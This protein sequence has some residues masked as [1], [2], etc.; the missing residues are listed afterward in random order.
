MKKI[1]LIIFLLILYKYSNGQDAVYISSYPE[2]QYKTKEDFINKRIWDTQAVYMMSFPPFSS[3]KLDSPED[4]LFFHY[5]SSGDKV[6]NMF[7][8]VYKGQLF[9]QHKSIYYNRNKE[10]NGLTMGNMQSYVRVMI[11]GE[12]YLYTEVAMA[13]PWASGMIGA[14]AWNDKAV[15]WDIKNKEFNVLRN[16]EDFNE[17]L[18]LNAPIEVKLCESNYIEQKNLRTIFKKIK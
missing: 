7:A 12:N 5:L 17:F 9:F 1:N 6:T 13:N 16:C 4:K 10:D 2:G 3:K 18:K 15:V 14:A 11:G 8:I